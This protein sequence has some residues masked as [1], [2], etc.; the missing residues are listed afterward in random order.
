[1]RLHLLI[2]ISLIQRA[3]RLLMQLSNPLRSLMIERLLCQQFLGLQGEALE[4]VVRLFESRILIFMQ[5]FGEIAEERV[6]DG[7]L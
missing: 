1:M 5:I 2:R 3:N 7:L 6:E 4:E